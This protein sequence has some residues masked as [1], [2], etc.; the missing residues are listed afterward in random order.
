MDKFTQF[1]VIMTA[2]C[3]L[4]I[5]CGE[6]G[7]VTTQDMNGKSVSST[8]G[9]TEEKVMVITPDMNGT[10]VSPTVG[11]TEEKV[12]VITQDMDGK[13][14]S[15]KVGDTFKV[16]LLGNPTTGYNW[17]ISDYDSSV[18]SQIGDVDYHADSSLVGSGGTY[19]YQFKALG[20]GA[21]IL[22][23]NY[24]RSWE[25]NV[26]PYKTFKVTIEVK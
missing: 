9:N 16:R 26:L 5:A 2:G 22:T 8:V 20:P 11:N 4:L 15:L 19:T 12:L 25:K 24:L 3:L 14:V 18:V 23:Y 1:L 21:T 13:S 17:V 7:L 10:L 6:K